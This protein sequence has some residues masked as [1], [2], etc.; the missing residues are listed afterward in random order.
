MRSILILLLFTIIIFFVYKYSYNHF[1]LEKIDTDIE[2]LILPN[3]YN[4]FYN[5]LPLNKLYK[6]MFTNK[7]IDKN[8]NKLEIPD[9]ISARN[10]PIEKKKVIIPQQFY[11]I[12]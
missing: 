9:E 11:L 4:D 7:N 12:F 5:Q 8:E 3:T 1:Y 2:Y 6:D 10:K